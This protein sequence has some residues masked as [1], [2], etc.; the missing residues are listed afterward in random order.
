MGKPKKPMFRAFESKFC[1]PGQKHKFTKIADDM[2]DSPAWDDLTFAQRGLYLTMKREYIPEKNTRGIITQPNDQH[3]MFPVSKWEK[4]YNRNY[5]AWKRDWTA[6]V[7]HGFI[8][9]RESGWNTRTPSVFA[10][11]DGW[12]EWTE[13]TTKTNK[14]RKT[15]RTAAVAETEEDGAEKNE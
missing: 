13:K 8:R 5:G 3:F 12:K 1:K 9:Q 6:L 4:G 11:D 14:T 10:F 2:M 15:R 7:E